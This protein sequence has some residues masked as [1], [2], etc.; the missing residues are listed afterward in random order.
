MTSYTAADQ[1]AVIAEAETV[2][3]SIDCLVFGAYSMNDL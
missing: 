2:W 1:S 3:R